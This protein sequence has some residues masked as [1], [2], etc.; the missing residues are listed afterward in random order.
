MTDL[1]DAAGVAPAAASTSSGRELSLPGWAGGLDSE[2]SERDRLIAQARSSDAARQLQRCFPRWGRAFEHLSWR[3]LV[4]LA[5][6]EPVDPN[7]RDAWRTADEHARAVLR[8][9]GITLNPRH[10]TL[11][12][13]QALTDGQARADTDAGLDWTRI[14]APASRLDEKLRRAHAKLPVD[15]SDPAVFGDVG[16]QR[17]ALAARLGLPGGQADDL[18]RWVLAHPDQFDA[19]QLRSWRIASP[20]WLAVAGEQLDAVDR[21]GRPV[22]LFVMPAARGEG[23][24]LTPVLSLDAIRLFVS[25]GGRLERDLRSAVLPAAA[26]SELIERINVHTLHAGPKECLDSAGQL[27]QELT[28][29]LGVPIGPGAPK[30]KRDRWGRL[31]VTRR[32]YHGP[33]GTT[34]CEL[35][36]RVVTFPAREYSQRRLGAVRRDDRYGQ[37]SAVMDLGEAVQTAV[38]R[39]LPLLLSTEAAGH[40]ADTVRVGRMKGRP[41]ALTITTL[42]RPLR[43]H[44]TSGRRAGDQRAT[45]AQ[46]Q[47]REGHIGRRRPPAARMSLARPLADD[48]VLLGRQQH[49]AALKVVGSGVDAGQVGSGKTVTSARALS[50]RATTTLSAA[51]DDRCRGPAARPMARRAHTRRTRP[52]AAAARAERRGAGH[53]RARRPIAGNRYARST[54]RSATARA[55]CSCRTGCLT[56]IPPIC[57]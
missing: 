50:H 3:A 5:K 47:W 44:A 38:E 30:D 17:R 6:N 35:E 22:A 41:G 52:R 4:V 48:P 51:G 19:A 9:H 43:H 21:V 49:M 2:R 18:S 40:L 26:A 8:R 53:R 28:R 56:G 36:L 33:D 42:G 12:A 16:A 24:Q 54:P 37:P 29:E 55:W 10:L 7:D 57:R 32:S 31:L 20:T 13:I 1:Y 45:H 23:W 25:L 46:A 11:A 39:G 34:T 14:T 15:L 27:A